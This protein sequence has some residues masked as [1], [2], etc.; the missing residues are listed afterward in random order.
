MLAT[1]PLVSIVLSSEGA[2]QNLSS[3]S[4]INPEAPFVERRFGT[5]LVATDTLAG[6][7]ILFSQSVQ[8]SSTLSQTL[9][10]GFPDG[11]PGLAS[12]SN[13]YVP[14]PLYIGEPLIQTKGI[15]R[16][17]NNLFV[18]DTGKDATHTEPAKIWRYDL[19]S[20]ELSVFYSGSLL[21]NSKWLA[22]SPGV[23]GFGPE[24]VVSDYGQEPSPREPGTGEGAKVFAIPLA[25]DGSAGEPRIIYAGSPL[26]SPEGIAVV[27]ST[28]ILADWAAGPETTRPE[29]PDLKFPTG[30]VF[31]IPLSGGEPVPLF[32]EHEFIILIGV[33]AFEMNGELFLEFTDIGSGRLDTSGRSPL[34]YE[35]TPEIFRAPIVSSDP[36]EVGELER[37]ILREDRLVSVSA[38]DLEEGQRL[39]FS[40]ADESYFDDGA[41]IRVYASDE[42]VQSHSIASMVVRNDISDERVDLIARVMD[43]ETV[44]SE[45]RLNFEK[46][47]GSDGPLAH[48]KKDSRIAYLSDGTPI[49]AGTDGTTSSVF[50]WP[51][52]GGTP[53]VIWRGAPLVAPIGMQ[54]LG[55]GTIYVTDQSAGPDGTSAIFKVA[56]PSDSEMVRMFSSR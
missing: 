37:V 10:M 29:V 33:D 44:I 18:S 55:D 54:T 20:G 40:F 43:G 3:L 17:G 36:F 6:A 56:V 5:D 38:P 49:M 34:P 30:I 9:S 19:D 13:K 35:G 42:L 51:E 2:A 24:I 53:G 45:E 25:S 21:V 26:R 8:N 46:P 4:P 52:N 32:P 47:L 1:I 22:Y 31:A 50:V 39:V 7:S 48:P 23:D 27:E 41:D 14:Q 12:I 11:E 16:V 15:V 28:I